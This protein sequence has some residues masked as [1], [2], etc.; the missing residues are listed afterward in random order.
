MPL[1][2]HSAVADLLMLV[3]TLCVCLCVQEFKSELEEEHK[4]ELA[5]LEAKLNQ[6]MKHKLKVL[7]SPLPHACMLVFSHQMSHPQM[8][9]SHPLCPPP[10]AQEVHI[11]QTMARA[12]KLSDE[13]L[14]AEISSATA[15]ERGV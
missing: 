14:A 12:C 8:Y 13:Q 11:I 15:G 9:L 1:V 6:Q 2:A 7:P 5:L 10:Q 4:R 3:G